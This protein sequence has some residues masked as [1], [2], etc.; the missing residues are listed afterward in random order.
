MD[1]D[2]LLPDDVEPKIR[3]GGE[4]IPAHVAWKKM[5]TVTVV[6][7]HIDRFNTDFPQLSSPATREVVP[8]V[9]RRLKEIELRIPRMPDVP[10]IG[11]EACALLETTAPE[12]VIDILAERHGAQLEIGQ[13]IQLA[14]EQAYL[15][16]LTR[17]AGEYA[18][19]RISPD[20]TAQLWNE[21]HRPA[22][23]GGLWSAAKVKAILSGG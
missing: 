14:G 15:R 19:N 12:D 13:L 17:E 1:L 22:P 9:R 10:D 18:H 8:L 6:V 2:S 20:Q 3:F 7:D 16:S 11:P 4:W 5:E 23:G 21:L